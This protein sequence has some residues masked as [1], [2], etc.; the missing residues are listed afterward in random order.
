[1]GGGGIMEENKVKEEWETPEI[2]IHSVNEETEGGSG[3]NW[4]EQD[5]TLS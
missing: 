1:M 5:N 3:T 2:T 4:D